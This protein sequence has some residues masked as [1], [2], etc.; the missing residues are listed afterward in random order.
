MLRA[1]PSKDRG[2]KL[3]GLMCFCTMMERNYSGPQCQDTIFKDLSDRGNP[4]DGGGRSISIRVLARSGK[5]TQSALAS[6]RTLRN[7]SRPA[8][9]HPRTDVYVHSCSTGY[10]QRFLYEE[11]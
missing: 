5:V 3:K 6:R 4:G 7:K 11:P 1:N 2:A 9:A 8:C 10:R